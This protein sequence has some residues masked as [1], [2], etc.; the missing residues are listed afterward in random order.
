MEIFSKGE[1]CAGWLST[2]VWMEQVC[3]KEKRLVSLGGDLLRLPDAERGCLRVPPAGTACARELRGG[4]GHRGGV[5]EPGSR[6][7]RQAPSAGGDAPGM[8]AAALS[9]HRSAVGHR[10]PLGA[11]C[12]PRARRSRLR[13]AEAR[14]RR[15][16]ERGGA[17]AR[18]PCVAAC[19]R[20]PRPGGGGAAEG[21]SPP[22]A[23]TA[24]AAAVTAGAQRLRG[25]VAAGD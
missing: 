9:A 17:A 20:A 13:G 10:A 8:S 11:P 3:R 7:W 23:A 4:G 12:A 6:G 19:S 14:A 1:K 15:G 2:V 5:A 21:A 24:A 25:S 22:A 16:A 18:G